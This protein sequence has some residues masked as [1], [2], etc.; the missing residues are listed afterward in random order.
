MD[1]GMPDIRVDEQHTASLVRQRDREIYRRQGFPLRGAGA[2]HGQHLHRSVSDG[3]FKIGLDRANPLR[4]RGIRRPDRKQVR[5]HVESFRRQTL[6]VLFRHLPL[7]RA[8]SIPRQHPQDRNFQGRLQ[9]VDRA[10][11]RRRGLAPEGSH[12]AKEQPDQTAP[13]EPSLQAERNDR[14]SRYRG[15]LNV[16]LFV[17][18]PGADEDLP[19]HLRLQSLEHVAFDLDRPFE[20]R[21]FR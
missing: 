12:R 20:P 19:L 16:H 7:K 1:T 11:G 4:L 21:K 8:G 10:Q 13:N 14:H 6:R 2:R 9:A 18:E 5:H 15:R 17:L 3:K